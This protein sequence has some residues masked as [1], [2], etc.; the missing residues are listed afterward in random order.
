VQKEKDRKHPG[1]SLTLLS[2]LIISGAFTPAFYHL[3]WARK[4]GDKELMLISA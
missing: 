4:K 3:S 2:I 1:M